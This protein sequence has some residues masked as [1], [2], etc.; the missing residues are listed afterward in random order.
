MK[1]YLILIDKGEDS[2]RKN[3][4]SFPRL[5]SQT[6]HAILFLQTQLGPYLNSLASLVVVRREKLYTMFRNSRGSTCYTQKPRRS[7]VEPAG[8]PDNLTLTLS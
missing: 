6:F 3:S 8:P 4:L 2:P 1:L 7:S 5:S